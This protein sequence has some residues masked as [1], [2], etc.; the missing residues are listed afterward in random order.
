MFETVLIKATRAFLSYFSNQMSEFPST[1]H[2]ELIDKDSASGR[3]YP[4]LLS[5]ITVTYHTAARKNP[6]TQPS[7]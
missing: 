6:I 5:Y 7:T 4:S 3:V 1:Y 2:S